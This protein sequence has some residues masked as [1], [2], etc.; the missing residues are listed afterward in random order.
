LFWVSPALQRSNK[1]LSNDLGAMKATIQYEYNRAEEVT[2]R[3]KEELA[4]A[5]LIR[6]G[7]NWDL[8]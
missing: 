1:K 6:R 4:L 3:A 5:M 7:A 8:V 2:E